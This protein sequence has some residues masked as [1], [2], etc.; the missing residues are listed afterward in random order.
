MNVTYEECPL[1]LCHVG[2]LWLQLLCNRNHIFTGVHH[3][4]PPEH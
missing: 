1:T 4:V 2:T 3:Y